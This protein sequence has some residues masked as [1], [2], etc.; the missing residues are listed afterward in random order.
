MAVTATSSLTATYGSALSSSRSD[1]LITDASYSG[2]GI[3]AGDIL[4]LSTFITG[5]QT[6]LSITTG[7]VTISGTSYTRIVM[8]ANANSTSTS[9][10]GNDK[11]VTVTATGSASTYTNT[12]YLF[13]TSTS[14]LASGAVIGTKI[15]ASYTQFPAGTS[16]NN[17]STRTYSGTTVYRVTFTQAANTSIAAASTVTFQFGAAYALPGET[18]FSFVNNPGNTD[19]I[20]LKDLKELTST[21]IGGRGTFPNGPDVLAINV[22]KI[23]GSA[24][25]ASLVIRWQ[26]AQ[27]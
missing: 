7:Y 23:S 10:A 8:S 18:V 14:W 21:A 24:T 12:N 20:D 3:A 19:T 17:I 16:V 5:N 13:F 25:N 22:Y 15:A 9:G 6:I 1:F 27:A 11:T 4:S 26:E 2:S